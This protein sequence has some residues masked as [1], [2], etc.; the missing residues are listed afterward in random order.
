VY[1][2]NFFLQKINKATADYTS[3]SLCT[4][5]IPF[6]PIGDAAYR[7]HAGGGPSHGIGNMHKSSAVAEMGDRG[8]NRHGPKRRGG[9]LCPFRGALGTRLHVIQCGMRRCLL[10]YQVA[11]SSIQ[12]FCHN[13]V[14]CHSPHRNIS[15]NYYLVVEMHTV[16]VRSDDARYLLN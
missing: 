15:T 9:V 5:V 14:G 2:S 11:S 10:P 7:Q 3:P 12:P 1:R 13:S 8:H 4:P 6:P 16:T